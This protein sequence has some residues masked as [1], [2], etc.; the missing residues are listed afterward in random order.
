MVVPSG[1]ATILYIELRGSHSLRHLHHLTATVRSC[2]MRGEKREKSLAGW[3]TSRRPL[4]TLSLPLSDIR[5]EVVD[6]QGEI[7]INLIWRHNPRALLIAGAILSCLDCE[8]G[9][10]VIL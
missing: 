3:I 4:T 2:I 7:V 1:P 8:D 6:K 5:E 10:F 9:Q